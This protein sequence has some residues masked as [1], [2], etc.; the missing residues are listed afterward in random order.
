MRPEAGSAS[1][2]AFRSAEEP[3]RGIE[4]ALEEI[5]AYSGS[6]YD[7]AVVEASVRLF[8]ERGFSFS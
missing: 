1:R 7:P 8:R 6:H 5:R 3:A 2:G 4:T